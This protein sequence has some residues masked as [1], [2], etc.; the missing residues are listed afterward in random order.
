MGIC[1]SEPLPPPR[2]K[3][4]EIK[5]EWYEENRILLK[6]LILKYIRQLEKLNQITLYI[7]MCI[8]REGHRVVSDEK[9]LETL[10]EV[11]FQ[12]FTYIILDMGGRCNLIISLVNN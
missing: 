9:I 5:P 11:I 12:P 10:K 3:Q 4:I 7:N 2:K 1:F 6:V 8:Y